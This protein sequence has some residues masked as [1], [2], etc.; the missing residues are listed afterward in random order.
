MNQ[1]VDYCSWI[2]TNWCWDADLWSVWA[3]GTQA[4]FSVLAIVASVCIVRRQDAAENKRLRQTFRHEVEQR[5][6]DALDAQIALHNGALQLIGAIQAIAKKCID[7]TGPVTARAED[8]RLMAIELRGTVE[9]IGRV[10]LLRFNTHLTSEGLQVAHSCGAALL[11]IMERISARDAL[12]EANLGYMKFQAEGVEALLM[13]RWKK[14]YSYVEELVK[15]H[16][17]LC[18]PIGTH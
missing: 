1:P 10:D 2:L 3:T 5:Q 18:Q 16:Q 15:K 13:P 4:V 9:A 8:I 17:A 6:A 14:L 7:H 11:S 12:W